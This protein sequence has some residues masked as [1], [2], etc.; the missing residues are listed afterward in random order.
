MLENH[1]KCLVSNLGIPCIMII[2]ETEFTLGHFPD[3]TLFRIVNFPH[4]SCQE[5]ILGPLHLATT[6]ETVEPPRL[7][8]YFLSVL[9]KLCSRYK[10]WCDVG[11]IDWP[12]R[13][14]LSHDDTSYLLSR[15]HIL[16]PNLHG[17]WH[18][19]SL[20]LLAYYDSSREDLSQIHWYVRKPYNA[21]VLY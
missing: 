18:Y 13:N 8:N 6:V 17:N 9:L 16:V 2:T 20:A 15:L 5:M 12:C 19:M 1:T 3:Q 10:V 11:P 4:W 14:C 7:S 21:L